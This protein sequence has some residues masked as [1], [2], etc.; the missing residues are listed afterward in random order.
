MD[1]QTYYSQ[2]ILRTA[3]L[4]QSQQSAMVGLAKLSEM[5]LGTGTLVDGLACVPTAPAT[6]NVQVN[7]GQIYSAQNLEATNWSTLSA[8]TTHS[9]VK[10]GVML[11][12]QQFAITPP[13]NAGYSQVF[14]IEAQYADFDTN[15][16]VLPYFN[17]ANP[18]VPLTGPGGSGTAQNTTRQGIVSLQVKAGV[19]ATTG[20]QVAPS[21]DAGW[22]G[23][24]LVTVAQGQSTITAGNIVQYPGAPFIK[25]ASNA[26]SAKLSEVPAVVQS[27]SWVG[28][29]DTSVTANT[30]SLALNPAPSSLT[31]CQEIRAKIANTVTGTTTATING[32]GPL[33]V[34]VVVPV[35]VLAIFARISWHT[36][37]DD[38]AGLSA[39]VMV[40]AVTEVSTH[41]TQLPD[42]TT[43]GTSESF[44][45][46][47]LLAFLMNGA[48]GY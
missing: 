23:L 20:T 1:R 40:F 12:S 35:T 46:P 41:P 17:S 27:G 45:E 25:N 18:S 47:A 31:V 33:M 30:I 37:R 16:A 2:E 24:W 42:C 13:T 26:G 36:V 21:V 44:A 28:C 48:P 4:L 22:T 19:A 43:A 39:R 15:S 6:L 29:V 8:D 7:P 10:Q 32:L 34:A 5:L 3:D 11:N 38:G 14:L 9:I